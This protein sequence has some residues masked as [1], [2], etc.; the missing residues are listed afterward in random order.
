MCIFI[1]FGY[2]PPSK[3]WLCMK[4]NPLESEEVNVSVTASASGRLEFPTSIRPPQVPA[5][6]REAAAPS[7]AWPRLRGLALELSRGPRWPAPG[8]GGGINGDDRAQNYAVKK[9]LSWAWS[10]AP[11]RGGPSPRG[12]WNLEP[13]N[14]RSHFLTVSLW[15]EGNRGTGGGEGWQRHQEE[16]TRRP[17]ASLA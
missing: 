6:P 14:P 11:A 3:N 4:P 12:V 5:F 1:Y 8:G 9:A 2:I 17:E 16:K 13:G 15:R 10:P 7:P